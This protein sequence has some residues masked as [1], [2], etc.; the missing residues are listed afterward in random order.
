MKQVAAKTKNKS[1]L[2]RFLIVA[3]CA[4]ML[5]TLGA[6][7]K[8]LSDSRETL[9]ATLNQ[10]KETSLRTE[11]KQNL[12]D[13]SNDQAIVERAARDH[14]YYYPYEHVFFDVNH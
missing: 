11:E 13:N 10:A 8:E 1:F 2:L 12:L 4:Y 14:G 5:V 6:L 9:N 3:F 7:F